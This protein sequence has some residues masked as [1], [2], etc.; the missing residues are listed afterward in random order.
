[1][2]I[3]NFCHFIEDIEILILHKCLL[4]SPPR[5]RQLLPKSLYSFG[6]YSNVKR[7]FSKKY[8]K[9]FFSEAVRWMKL[10][11]CIHAYDISLYKVYV[12]LLSLSHYFGCY[13]NLKF[14]FTYKTKRGK[15]QFLPFRLKFLSFDSWK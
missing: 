7:K 13:G 6:C 5:F 11:L 9:L 8:S 10:K 1:M 15:L 3:C 4:S 14:P 2:E 12:F